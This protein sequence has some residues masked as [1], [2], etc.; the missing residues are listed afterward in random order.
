MYASRHVCVSAGT[1]H[2]PGAEMDFHVRWGALVW[3]L[4]KSR[5]LSTIMKCLLVLR[6]SP[7][8]QQKLSS[9]CAVFEVTFF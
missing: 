3:F 7:L 5:D 2:V 9:T 4:R 6:P 8:L 1:A